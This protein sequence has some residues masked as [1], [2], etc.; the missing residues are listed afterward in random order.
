MDIKDNKIE[1]S[2]TDEFEEDTRYRQCNKETIAISILFL[3]N[4]MIAML[5]AYFLSR[6]AVSDFGYTLGMPN[7]VFYSVMIVPLAFVAIT[8]LVIRVFFKDVP[9]S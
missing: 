7:W 8:Y 5:L 3:L 4:G 9:L 1:G 2:K 6:G